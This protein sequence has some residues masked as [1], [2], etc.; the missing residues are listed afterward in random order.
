MGNSVDAASKIEAD[1][2]NC[3]LLEI[4]GLDEGENVQIQPTGV[5]GNQ[6][7]EVQFRIAPSTAHPTKTCEVVLIVT[8]EGN[9][10]ERSTSWTIDV[11]ESGGSQDSNTGDTGSSSSNSGSDSDSSSALP[12]LGAQTLII[13]LGFVALF[14]RK[15][16]DVY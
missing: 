13:L 5:D 7:T 11:D 8:S 1:V 9:G 14:H 12:T 2:R 10:L 15:R 4:E 3:P 6:P 16:L